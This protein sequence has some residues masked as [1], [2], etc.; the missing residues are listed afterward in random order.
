MN[1]RQSIATMIGSVI[2]VNF[3]GIASQDLP[4]LRQTIATR[5]DIGIIKGWEYKTLAWD[6]CVILGSNLLPYRTLEPCKIWKRT[7]VPDKGKPYDLPS[8]IHSYEGPVVNI[9]TGEVCLMSVSCRSE[10]TSPVGIIN[11]R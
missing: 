2:V 8:T 3:L 9:E 6:T 5:I 11:C 10:G 7:F 4:L 1:R